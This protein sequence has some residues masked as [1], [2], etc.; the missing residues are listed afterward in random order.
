MI[1]V[2]Y[3]VLLRATIKYCVQ[4]LAQNY[5]K[6]V[7]LLEHVRTP[8]KVLEHKA[9]DEW[10]SKMRLFKLEKRMLR[11]ELSHSS[12]YLKRGCSEVGVSISSNNS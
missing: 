2:M 1:V 12:N 7:Q 10:L 11:A 4:F 3:L 5:K 8:L 9:Y 6:D